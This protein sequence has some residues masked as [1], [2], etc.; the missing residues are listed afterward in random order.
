MADQDA[1]RGDT[2]MDT[3]MDTGPGTGLSTGLSTGRDHKSLI[4]VIAGSI[5][6]L[7]LV[8]MAF[9][10]RGGDSVSMASVQTPVVTAQR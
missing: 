5:L 10:D 2:G 1:A 7:G 4:Y 3:G 6:A 8:L 9:Y